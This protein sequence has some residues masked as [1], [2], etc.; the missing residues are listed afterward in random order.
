MPPSKGDG[1][2]DGGREEGSRVMIRGAACARARL[3]SH[4][5]RKSKKQR[6]DTLL[7]ERR[8]NSPGHGVR[9]DG[10]GAGA[11]LRSFFIFQ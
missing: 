4:L 6:T 8:K 2:G 3:R 7:T 1:M 11:G 10:N 9:G 5:A